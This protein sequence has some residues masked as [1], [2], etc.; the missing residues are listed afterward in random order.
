MLHVITVY[1]IIARLFIL[2]GQGTRIATNAIDSCT[3]KRRMVSEP[4]V[5]NQIAVP[6]L[7]LEHFILRRCARVLKKNKATA[8]EQV[9]SY[10][11]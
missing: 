7:R 4:L 5:G 2:N 9:A 1:Y 3:G 10:V 6:A 8:R 11:Y